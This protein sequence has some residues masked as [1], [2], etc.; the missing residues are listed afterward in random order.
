[1]PPFGSRKSAAPP[2]PEPTPPEPDPTAEQQLAAL[3]T[4]R[5]EIEREPADQSE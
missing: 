4:E 1:M 5:P 2:P 3:L